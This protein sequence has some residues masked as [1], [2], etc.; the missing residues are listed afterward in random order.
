MERH[1]LI[2]V[3]NAFRLEIEFAAVFPFV[4]VGFEYGFND[5]FCPPDAGESLFGLNRCSI[6]VCHGVG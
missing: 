1:M 4:D 3:D 6:E 2:I 5:G